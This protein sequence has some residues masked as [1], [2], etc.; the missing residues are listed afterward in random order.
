MVQLNHTRSW[1]HIP[2][3]NGIAA[4]AFRGAILRTD[5]HEFPVE[6]SGGGAADIEELSGGVFEEVK[7][8]DGEEEE[9]RYQA[10]EDGEIQRRANL[11]H[12]ISKE[13]IPFS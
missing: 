6:T 11:M 4:R 1:G 12:L 9:S 13:T 5:R 10:S 2:V 8:T 7:D 3:S